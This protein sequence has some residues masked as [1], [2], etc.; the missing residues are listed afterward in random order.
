MADER[1]IAPRLGAH[2]LAEMLHAYGVSHIFYIP[3]LIPNALAAM[4]D[5]GMRRVVTHGEKAAAYMADGFAR[6]S[7]RPA[8]CMSQHIGGSNLAAGLRDAYLAGSPVIALAGS[9]A[10]PPRSPHA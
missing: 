1:R 2:V 4:E 10:P 3:C 7:G 8:V 5:L 9:V 6:A